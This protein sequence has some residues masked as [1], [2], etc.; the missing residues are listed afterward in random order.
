M[1]SIKE[2]MG[3]LY[4]LDGQKGSFAPKVLAGK[5][6]ISKEKLAILKDLAENGAPPPRFPSG[7]R[8]D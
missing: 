7:K 8:A 4:L 5:R 1:G 2:L 3:L 6:K